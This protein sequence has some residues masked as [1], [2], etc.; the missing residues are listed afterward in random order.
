VQTESFS[1]AIYLGASLDA[2]IKFTYWFGGG[3]S[4]SFGR[5]NRDKWCEYISKIDEEHNIYDIFDTL[6]IDERLQN[7]DTAKISTL[8]DKVFPVKWY[9][10]H[11]M[12]NQPLNISGSYNIKISGFCTKEQLK[13]IEKDKKNKKKNRE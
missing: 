2:D 4:G 12:D 6:Y 1:D 13:K 7:I 3:V 5:C 9:T 10:N 8:F 11:D